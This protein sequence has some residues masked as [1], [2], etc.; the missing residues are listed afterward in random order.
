[1]NNNKEGY[2]A[3]RDLLNFSGK[4][5]FITGAGQGLGKAIA[6]RLHEAGA[7][8][9][10]A[11]RNIS[12]VQ[13]LATALADKRALPIELDVTDADAVTAAFARL[14]EH[15]G[16]LDVLVN[17]VGIYGTEPAENVSEETLDRYYELN[18]KSAFRCSKAALP[19]LKTS[20]AAVILNIES[21]SSYRANVPGSSA[22]TMSKH[23]LQGLTKTFA[24]DFSEYGIRVLGIA[25]TFVKTEGT[26]AFLSAEI[27]ATM[28][29]RTPLKRVALPDDIAKVALFCASEMAG[30]MTGA[31]VLV[32]GGVLLI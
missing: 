18:I 11:D 22:Y 21:I 15:Y 3:N 28:V 2:T 14:D 5:A 13:A 4:T 26:C 7:T 30:Y 29:A 25:P 20:A 24:L 31:T 9:F 12:A 16:S 23:G 1:M 10:L 6:E 19:L 27:E 32:D 17:N 8:V